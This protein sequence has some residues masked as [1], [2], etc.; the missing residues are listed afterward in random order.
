MTAQEA[1]LQLAWALLP[2]RVKRTGFQVLRELEAIKSVFPIGNILI[3]CR[4]RS[5]AQWVSGVVGHK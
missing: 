3:Y 5:L 1:S 4:L 2:A